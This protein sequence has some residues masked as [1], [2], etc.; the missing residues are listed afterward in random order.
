MKTKAMFAT[1]LCLLISALILG[2]RRPPAEVKAGEPDK[3]VT[4]KAIPGVIA[5]GAKV[6]KV[7]QGDKAADG[8]ISLPDGTLILPEQ[9]ADRISKF[10]VK[11]GK[12]TPWFEDT[13]EAGGVAVTSKGH[14]ITVER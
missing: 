3:P 12:V 11:T 6:E 13:N 8:L 2:Q 9:R 14:I 10:D 4:V 1:A 5:A 7:W